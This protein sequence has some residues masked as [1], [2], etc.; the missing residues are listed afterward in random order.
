VNPFSTDFNPTPIVG[1]CETVALAQAPQDQDERL[2]WRILGRLEALALHKYESIIPPL[3]TPAKK[4]VVALLAAVPDQRDEATPLDQPVNELLDAAGSTD[5]HDT[6]FVQGFILERLG[7]V[8]YRK[9]A[10][11]PTVSG[12]TRAVAEIGGAACTA[13]IGRA[14]DLIHQAYGEGEAAFDRFCTAADA[15]LR[16]LDGLGTGVDEMFGRRFGLTFSELMGEF[17][18]ELLPACMELGMNRRK[19]VCHLAGVF[20]GG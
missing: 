3:A 18:A 8:I 13:I 20:M 7:Q 6:L 5:R 4:A 14:T 11:H 2:I 17:T 1:V 16:R 12:P 10:E 9:L 19:L 15:V